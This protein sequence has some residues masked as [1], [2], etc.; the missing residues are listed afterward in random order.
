M[1]KYLMD[2][3]HNDMRTC[4]ECGGAF[5]AS[6][7]PS[8]E[9]EEW[10]CDACIEAEA[11]ITRIRDALKQIRDGAHEHGTAWAQRVAR[12]ALNDV[13]EDPPDGENHEA[14]G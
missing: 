9:E 1:S 6:R 10:T 13:P 3:G 14:Q 8:E 7:G 12:K 5:Y 2:S 4:D 11:A